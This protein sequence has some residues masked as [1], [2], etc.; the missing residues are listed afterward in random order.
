[1]NILVI[2]SSMRA[3]SQSLKVSNWL[4]EHIN[5]LTH[6]PRILDLH[7]FKLPIFDDGETAAE[8]AVLLLE[9]VIKA[10]AY[11]FVSPEWNGMM[12]LGLLNMLHYVGHEMAYKPVM[13]VGVSSGRGGTH[14]IDQMK[15]VG[16]KNRHYIISPDNLIV[17]GVES[18][19]NDNEMTESTSD[20]PLKS[21]ADYSLKMLIE[22]AKS[23]EKVRSSEVINLETFGNGV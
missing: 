14:P 17:S 23:L 12:S 7:S 13:L 22:L 10:D 20:Y 11:V 2:S 4:G 15:L 8:N 16:Q 21:R 1:M 5:S 3:N 19:F 9:I 18:A 6:E